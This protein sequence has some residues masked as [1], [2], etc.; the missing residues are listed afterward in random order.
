MS[1][2]YY[3]IVYSK[4]QILN[5]NYSII[6]YERLQL[7]KLLLNIIYRKTDAEFDLYY[8]DYIS[9]FKFE[10]YYDRKNILEGYCKNIFANPKDFIVKTTYHFIVFCFLT[11]LAIVMKQVL[12]KIPLIFFALFH[13]YDTWWFLTHEGNAPI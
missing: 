2:E 9:S 12:L 3:E 11:Y 6:N 8:Y 5:N 10:K 7:L 4:Y 1:R 13:L